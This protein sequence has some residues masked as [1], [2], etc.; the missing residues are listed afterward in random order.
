M[1]R[2]WRQG[3]IT[4]IILLVDMDIFIDE[5]G[6]VELGVRDK[7][8]LFF[9]IGS[10]NASKEICE[11]AIQKVF[12]R[13]RPREL[14]FQNIKRNV[15]KIEKLKRVFKF[16]LDEGREIRTYTIYKP[17]YMLSSFAMLCQDK[18]LEDSGIETG[19]EDFIKHRR[20]FIWFYT[21]LT[22]GPD[23][24]K[25]LIDSY[26]GF[27]FNPEQ[28]TLTRLVNC[29]DGAKNDSLNIFRDIKEYLTNQKDNL[30]E[31]V[32]K[33]KMEEKKE[34]QWI[35][36]LSWIDLTMSCT[37]FLLKFW[38]KN[39]EEKLDVCHDISIPLERRAGFFDLMKES[40]G[41]YV[42]S[43]QFVDSKDYIEVQLS[44]LI[45][46]AFNFW[47]EKILLKKIGK[48]NKKLEDKFKKVDKA[49]KVTP[50]H[51]HE[52]MIPEIECMSPRQSEIIRSYMFGGRELERFCFETF[53]K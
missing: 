32:S 30:I 34:F 23:F 16:L 21:I 41:S 2:C 50:N 8:Q 37:R 29:I 19:S 52:H 4:G 53:S 18:I 13:S 31:S 42:S 17:F 46:G 35:N 33:K 3:K 28:T 9:T 22:A 49:I 38:G 11:Q 1:L 43:F 27:I 10:H 26:Q 15:E 47:Y 7:S 6:N 20:N 44:D 14:K 48:I 12:G 36:E 39:H 45:A 25:Q 40:D 24:L 51:F 5:S